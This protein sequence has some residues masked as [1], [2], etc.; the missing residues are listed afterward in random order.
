MT[1]STMARE[2][3]YLFDGFNTQF[4]D[5]KFVL[6]YQNNIKPTPVTKPIVAISIK[7]CQISDKL[8]D[9]LDT[10]EIVTTSSRNVKITLS[11][12]IYLPYSFD[13]IKAV[14]IYD[15]LA[16]VLLFNFD[17]HLAVTGSTC[18][19]SEYDT[20]CQAIVLKT[21]FTLEKTLDE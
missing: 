16:T 2:I 8:K 6:A 4:P 5:V 17:S 21:T 18:G 15:R 7:D 13:G 19:E 10:G 3:F 9:V 1:I 14:S 11:M 20:S 12:D